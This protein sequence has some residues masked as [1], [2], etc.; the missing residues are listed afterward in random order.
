MAQLALAWVL[1]RSEISSVVVGAT[2]I[3]HI[4]SNIKASG[5]RLSADVLEE[6]ECILDGSAV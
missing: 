2:Q 4:A 5:I 3:A 6:V 1:R